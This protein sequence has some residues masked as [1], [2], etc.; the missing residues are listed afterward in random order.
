MTCKYIEAFNSCD[1]EAVKA[2]I[3]PQFVLEEPAGRFEG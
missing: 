3:A 1:I 2:C